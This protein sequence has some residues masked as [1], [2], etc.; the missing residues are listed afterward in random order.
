[1]PSLLHNW[2]SVVGFVLALVTSLI[3]LFLL[4]INFIVGIESP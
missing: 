1:L 4:G 2:R 3:I